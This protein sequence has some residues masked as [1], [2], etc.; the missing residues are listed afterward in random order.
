MNFL[1]SK[2]S[3]KIAYPETSQVIQSL[4][5]PSGKIYNITLFNNI[6]RCILGNETDHGNI[7]SRAIYIIDLNNQI[8]NCIGIYEYL[9]EK[10]REVLYKLKQNVLTDFL[11]FS[12]VNPYWLE[13]NN[14][15]Y[16]NYNFIGKNSGFPNK[17]NFLENEKND[18]ETNIEGSQL[19]I[20][21]SRWLVE[22]LSTDY[23]EVIEVKKKL[24]PLIDRIILEFKK[25]NIHLKH[26]TSELIAQTVINKISEKIYRFFSGNFI[27][28]FKYQLEKKELLKNLQKKFSEINELFIDVT[29]YQSK[30]DNIYLIKKLEKNIV[31]IKKQ[32]QIVAKYLK[33]F[34]F[35]KKVDTYDLFLKTVYNGTMTINPWILMELEKLFKVKLIVLSK[36]SYES[37]DISNI[38]RM[39]KH[40]LIN[41]MKH[42]YDFFVLIEE[43]NT[44]FNFIKNNNRV[45]MTYNEIPQTLKSIMEYHFLRCKNIN[46]KNSDLLRMVK[47]KT[48][49][50][51]LSFA[52]SKNKKTFSS[53]SLGQINLKNRTRKALGSVAKINIVNKVNLYDSS[54]HLV[55]GKN[56]SDKI[57]PGDANSEY[58]ESSADFLMLDELFVIKDWRMLLFELS[59]KCADYSELVPEKINLTMDE[60]N[61][62][63][64]TVNAK[65]YIYKENL[66]IFP[67]YNLMILRQNL[68]L[69]K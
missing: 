33:S 50:I 3:K 39:P 36:L 40:P 48:N 53:K 34:S 59:V 64:A 29:D 45:I 58:V 63:E 31:K 35:M 44:N 38:V 47:K 21:K 8:A 12:F 13:K 57:L 24:T 5:D 32:I 46:F 1:F 69:C 60:K 4:V 49:N 9:K 25:E 67:D 42:N 14:L 20:N 41:K 68:R 62:I 66:G 51:K 15:I 10:K 61:L 6:Y 27:F 30:V 54:V 55:Y 65:L 52:R 56:T 26:L 23:L 17:S 37:G 11:L 18:N 28:L 16:S 19:E 43:T 22:Y 2:K 7:C